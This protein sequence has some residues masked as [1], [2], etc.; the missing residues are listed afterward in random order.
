MEII[1]EKQRNAKNELQEYRI[2]NKRNK[3]KK[4]SRVIKIPTTS[5]ILKLILCVNVE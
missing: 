1:K 2:K 4:Y 5:V 3:N